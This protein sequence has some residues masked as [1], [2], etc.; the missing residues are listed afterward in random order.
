MAVTVRGK[1]GRDTDLEQRNLTPRMFSAL[2]LQGRIWSAG[3]TP[4]IPS[5]TT[6]QGS[7]RHPPNY[8]P[9][10]ESGHRVLINRRLAELSSGASTEFRKGSPIKSVSAQLGWLYRIFSDAN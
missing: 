6:Q 1:R 7:H 8:A 3:N 9:L 2:P 10:R 5:P 4:Q